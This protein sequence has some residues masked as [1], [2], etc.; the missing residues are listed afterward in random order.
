MK[1][2]LLL[3]VGF[4]MAPICVVGLFW[5]WRSIWVLC[6]QALIVMFARQWHHAYD[7]LSA[8]DYPDLVVGSLYYP[9]VGWL[10]SRAVQ[11]GKL[12]RIG[13]SVGL[14]HVVAIGVA[15]AA[16]G[17]RNRLWGLG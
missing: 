14:W 12:A 3:F 5:Q 8:A 17:L 11:H 15:W 1:A 7:S 9:I 2:K 16:C 4:L 13:V 6:P 10:L